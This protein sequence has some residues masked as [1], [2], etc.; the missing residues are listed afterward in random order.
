M[1]SVWFTGFITRFRAPCMQYLF[2]A[3]GSK[4]KPRSGLIAYL[5]GAGFHSSLNIKTPLNQREKRLRRMSLRGFRLSKVITTICKLL[6]LLD[7]HQIYAA[8][9]THRIIK[10]YN[11]ADNRCH[12]LCPFD[13]LFHVCLLSYPVAQGGGGRICNRSGS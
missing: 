6:P 12:A 7:L 13:R 8:P 3:F 10:N 5:S 1:G 11:P 4:W 9:C 2:L